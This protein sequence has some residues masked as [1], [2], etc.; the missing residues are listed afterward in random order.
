MDFKSYFKIFPNQTKLDYQQISNEDNKQTDRGILGWTTE[1]LFNNSIRIFQKT[2][3]VFAHIPKLKSFCDSNNFNEISTLI[4]SI[5][6]TSTKK[7]DLV[8]FDKVANLAIIVFENKPK[9]VQKGYSEEKLFAFLTTIT[10]LQDEF[11]EKTKFEKY[12]KTLAG[13][14]WHVVYSSQ[15]LEKYGKRK[16]IA[17]IKYKNL[18]KQQDE[19]IE[20]DNDGTYI[21]NLSSLVKNEEDEL[22]FAINTLK[23][24]APQKDKY[25]S[26]I[27]KY[28]NKITK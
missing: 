5:E 12:Q 7:S 11:T 28:R 16:A 14:F 26:L 18:A 10:S 24:G 3:Q 17:H 4:N 23:K 6:L 19:S 9:L 2:K 1:A 27:D 13:D 20:L 21:E 15:S 25:E 22:L 8:L